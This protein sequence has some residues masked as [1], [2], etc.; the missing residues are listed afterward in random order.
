VTRRL[1]R[2]ALA[3]CVLSLALVGLAPT[4]ARAGAGP[5]TLADGTWVGRWTLDN[6]LTVTVR[7]IPE[8][9]GVALITAFRVGREQDPKGREGMAD[10]L[11]EM[12]FT[13]AAG[14]LPERPREELQ[15]L[16][17]LGWTVQV[18]PRFSLLSEIVT[19][20]QLPGALRQAAARLRG[21]TVDDSILARARR[22]TVREL[23]R[24]YVSSPD[25]TLFNQMRDLASGVPD[26]D[27]IRRIAG[28]TLANLT[29]REVRDRLRRLYVPANAVL[30][31]AGNLEEVDVQVLVRNLFEGIPAGVAQP[32]PPLTPLTAVGRAMQRSGLEHAVGAVGIIAPAITD[33]LHPSFYLN[34]LVIGKFCQDTWGPPAPPLT[35]RFRYPVFADAQLAQFFPP[36]PPGE[37]DADQLGVVFQDMMERMASS[38]IGREPFDEARSDNQWLFGGTLAPKFLERMRNHSGPLHTLGSTLAVRALWGSEEFWAEY[39]ARFTD[40]NATHGDVWSDYFKDP[41]RIVRL[42]LTPAR[43]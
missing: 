11:A 40:P 8:S 7:H 27:L 37:T 18:T 15:E 43:R 31:L 22:T 26:E 30:A 28:R 6:G 21:V 23:G 3:C 42:L 16:R 29:A 9:N 5:D 24:R 2:N 17:P 38:V 10:L 4:A 20:R 12:L 36:V 34:S 32:E 25:L 14:E 39:L 33:S 41:H 13:G 1:A 35:S 19:P